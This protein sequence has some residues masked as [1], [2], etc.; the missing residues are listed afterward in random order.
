MNFDVKFQE[1]S[2][3]AVEMGQLTRGPKGDKGDKGDPGPTGPQGPKGDTGPQGPQGPKGPQGEKGET[4][5]PDW[6]QND[7]TAADYVKNRPFYS[8]ETAREVLGKDFDA[9]KACVLAHGGEISKNDPAGWP[10]TFSYKS[11]DYSVTATYTDESESIE[12]ALTNFPEITGTGHYAIVVHAFAKTPSVFVA[13]RQGNETNDLFD[14]VMPAKEEV[15]YLSPKFIKDMYYEETDSGNVQICSFEAGWSTPKEVTLSEPLIEGAT[16][17]ILFDGTYSTEEVCTFEEDAGE[18]WLR[19]QKS[20]QDNY[21]TLVATN[22]ASTAIQY[23][24]NPSKVAD[25]TVV[26]IA[27]KVT[28]FHQIPAKYIPPLE[29]LTVTFTKDDDGNCSADKTF[30][31][32]KAAIE[33]GRFVQAVVVDYG[34]SLPACI[35][36]DQQVIFSLSFQKNNVIMQTFA[37]MTPTFC[38]VREMNGGLL[39]L[40][41]TPVY[42]GKLAEK[43]DDMTQPVGVDAAGKLWTKPGGG[44]LTADGITTALG[45]TPRKA[46]YV[47]L[48]GTKASPTAD[49]TAVAIYQAYT[50]G[51][52]VYGIVQM[53]EI[54]EGFPIIL[55]L[56]Y[57]VSWGAITALCFAGSANPHLSGAMT[58]NT[59]ITATYDGSWH[60]FVDS[61]PTALKNPNALTFTGAVT[62]TYDGSEPVSVN[63]PEA[64]GVTDEQV[65]DAVNTYLDAHPEATTTVQDGAVTLSK[66]NQNLAAKL[67]LTAGKLM[68]DETQREG[69]AS[70]AEMFQKVKNEVMLNYMGNINKIP[71]IVHTDQHGA[72]NGSADIVDVFETIDKLVNWQDI[73]KAINL[74]DCVANA[75][76]DASDTP[77]LECAELEN[78]VKSTAPVPLEKQLNVFGNHDRYTWDSA[79]NTYG[80]RITD[81]SCLQQYF[82]NIRA[83]RRS[84]NGWFTVEDGYFNVKYLITS[85]YEA[86]NNFASTVQ[87]D[88]LISEL[89][90]DDGYDIVLLAHELYNPDYARRLFPTT[91]DMIWKESAGN[92]NSYGMGININTILTARKEKT[93]GTFTDASGVVHTFDFTGCKTELL[94]SLHGHTHYETYNYVNDDY[95]NVALSPMKHPKRWLF[96][97]LIDRASKKLKVWKMPTAAGL[98]EYKYEKYEVPF[99]VTGLESFTIK[100]RLANTTVFNTSGTIKQGQPYSQYIRAKSGYTLG[101]VSVT[102]GGEDIT[103]NCYDAE[104]GLVHIDAV[105]GNLVIKAY[106][107]TTDSSVT[108]VYIAVIFDEGISRITSAGSGSANASVVEGNVFSFWPAIKDG[109][110][111]NEIT[112]VDSSKVNV[113]SSFAI[114]YISGKFT[115]VAANDDY[116]IAY[117]TAP[118]TLESGYL[119]LNGSFTADDRLKTTGF[120]AV[121][122]HSIVYFLANYGNT[123][124]VAEYDKD[125]NFIRATRML[126][127]RG[128]FIGK[129]TAFVRYSALDWPSNQKIMSIYGLQLRNIADAMDEVLVVNDETIAAAAYTD[130]TTATAL[131]APNLVTIEA[132]SIGFKSTLKTLIAPNLT[133]L[134][135]VFANGGIEFA[136]IDGGASLGSNVFTSSYLFNT[137]ILR[138]DTLVAL[139]SAACFLNTP[140]R[141]YS[142]RR[143]C[144][145]VPRALVESYKTAENWAAIYNAGYMDILA[146]EDCGLNVQYAAIAELDKTLL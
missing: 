15:K 38:D 102:M 86:S 4:V 59:T 109:Y 142:S 61:Q 82:R 143:G 138:S 29:P 9:W 54:L 62:G 63:I 28:G 114:N 74:G 14:F 94:C 107:T 7:A 26:R 30:A 133:T 100:R 124:L 111:I 64:G 128:L 11:K 18:L 83:H 105:T 46:W 79:A 108:Y 40:D 35:A 10:I 67:D 8:K 93:A 66:L 104:T 24:G 84:N 45:Y 110:R 60:V 73:S 68:G 57:A 131:I 121:G 36:N 112:A 145:I 118:I 135:N 88:F 92:D 139:A 146:I 72:L 39:P 95:L 43:T 23:A 98:T 70:F 103:A 49:Q 33:A 78:A 132:N 6:E 89:G 117:T 32:V 91:S 136:D 65:A 120:E 41:D 69:A 76:K 80:A 47:K 90:K 81:Q 87:I 134:P 127:N 22:A 19:I 101:D 141:G 75:W 2:S 12:Y 123:R 1:E 96:F 106:D 21:G 44:S 129:N 126:S 85:A 48:T 144:L 27:P 16:Y 97:C 17:K 31:E 42:E 13:T 34:I 137:L 53:S 52:A 71:V 113:I 119:G 140:F 58:Q 55:P 115:N 125:K 50:D 99:G 25:I 130:N 51:Y 20:P 56:L 116:E 3:F 37:G 5:Q 122:A 77:W